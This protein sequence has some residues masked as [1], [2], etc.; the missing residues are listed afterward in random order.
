MGLELD[1]GIVYSEC[2]ERSTAKVSHVSGGRM[3]SWHSLDYTWCPSHTS[4]NPSP[5][6][7]ITTG[8]WKARGARASGLTRGLWNWVAWL[9]ILVW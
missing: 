7:H 2:R 5:I 6:E 3:T 8:E 4:M 9:R 1:V